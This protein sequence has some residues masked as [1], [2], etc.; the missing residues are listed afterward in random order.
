MSSFPAHEVN[1]KTL[2]AMGFDVSEVLDE[3]GEV[4]YESWGYDEQVYFYEGI[5]S[6]LLSVGYKHKGGGSYD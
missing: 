2:Q 1:V 5:V 6:Q 3:N 4:L